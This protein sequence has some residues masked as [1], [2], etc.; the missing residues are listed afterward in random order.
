MNNGKLQKKVQR[1][2]SD[3]FC[4]RPGIKQPQEQGGMEFVW[5]GPAYQAYGSKRKTSAPQPESEICFGDEQD[6]FD[7]LPEEYR[8]H[9]WKAF[10]QKAGLGPHPGKYRGPAVDPD[11]PL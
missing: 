2:S 4:Q 8:E 6:E 10:I 9:L 7:A 5:N 11:P 3:E 1:K